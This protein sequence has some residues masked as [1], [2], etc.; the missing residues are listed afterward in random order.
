MLE[1][2][3]SVYLFLYFG[4]ILECDFLSTPLLEYVFLMC[5]IA[6]GGQP[7]FYIEQNIGVNFLV[8]YVVWTISTAL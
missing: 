6:R 5:C 1:H 3:V 4:S 8:Y 7:R 2:H